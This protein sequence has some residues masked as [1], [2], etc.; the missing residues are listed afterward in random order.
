MSANLQ[1][2]NFVINMVDKSQNALKV[3]TKTIGS[4]LSDFEK[5]MNPEMESELEGYKI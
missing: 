1:G 4:A 3:M 5:S 2:G